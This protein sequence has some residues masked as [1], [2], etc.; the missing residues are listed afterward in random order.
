MVTATP[1]PFER[2]ALTSIQPG[3]HYPVIETQV[4]TLGLQIDSLPL[5]HLAASSSLPL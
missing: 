1:L 5:E 4:R 2:K 3:F